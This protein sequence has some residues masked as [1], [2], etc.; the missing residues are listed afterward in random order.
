[1]ITAIIRA[2]GLPACLVIGLLVYYEGIPGAYRV[3]FLSALPVIGDLATGRVHAHA[4]DQVRQA[5][6]G[7]IAK[8]EIVALQAK[9][10][11]QQWIAARSAEAAREAARRL[12]VEATA[13]TS[14]AARLLAIQ[15]ENEILNDDLADLLSR[16]VRDDCTVDADLLGR[17][18]AR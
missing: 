15:T 14:L 9:L 2:V 12:S 4:A 3:P 6:A 18:R 1:M 13:R 10:D 17:M 8:A 16:P 11:A 5:T 7:L